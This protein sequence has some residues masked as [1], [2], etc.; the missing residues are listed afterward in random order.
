[1]AG[2]LD[3]DIDRHVVNARN[4]FD[5]RNQALAQPRNLALGGV[6][7]FHVKRHV[8]AAYLQV[9]KRFAADKIFTRIGVQHGLQGV[10]NGLLL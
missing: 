9:F 10:Q 3:R 2:D 4:A 8:T 5:G 6:A 1:M 7:Q